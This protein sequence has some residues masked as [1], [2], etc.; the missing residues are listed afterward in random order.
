MKTDTVGISCCG[1]F[2]QNNSLAFSFLLSFWQN[3]LCWFLKP[4][5]HWP[6]SGA[7]S[8]SIPVAQ[9]LIFK[10]FHS[11]FCP[12]NKT[13][14]LTNTEVLAQEQ[15]PNIFLH[16]ITGMLRKGSRGYLPLSSGSCQAKRALQDPPPP[17]LSA[18]QLFG[19][20]YMAPVCQW[21]VETNVPSICIS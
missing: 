2:K 7:T 8:C 12:I 17:L 4:H 21:L 20:G 19:S 14:L 18:V 13:K 11:M 10:I 16:F 5:L 1:K 3:S 15:I 6:S 9:L